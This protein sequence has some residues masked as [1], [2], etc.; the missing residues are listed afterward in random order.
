MC[1]RLAGAF[2]KYGQLFRD[3]MLLGIG[4]A[5]MS[6]FCGFIQF[7]NIVVLDSDV[8]CVHVLC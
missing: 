7:I 4:P 1:T 5:P 2:K 8:L 3:G 6:F